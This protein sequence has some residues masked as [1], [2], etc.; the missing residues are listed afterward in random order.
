MKKTILFEVDFKDWAFYFMVKSWSLKLADEYDCYYVCNEAYR[1][2][3]VKKRGSVQIFLWNLLAAIRLFSLK[4]FSCDKRKVQFIHPSGN[5][6]FPRYTKNLIVPFEDESREIEKVNFDFLV[7]MAYFFQYSSD[8]PFKGT[9]NLV[10]IFNDCFP[11]LGPAYDIK[12]KTDVNALSRG[13]FFERYLKHY[14]F[15]LLANDNLINAYKEYTHNLEFALG[16]YKEECFGIK[17]I[18]S[19]IFT[20]GWTGNPHRPVKG[21]F[22]VIEPAVE[23]VLATGRQV[24]LKTSFN[25]SYEKMIEF[26]NDVDLAVIASSGDGAPTMFCEACL[27]HIPSVSTFIG[28]PSMVI[29]DGVNGIFINRDIDEMANAIIYLYDNRDVLEAFS[30]RIKHDYCEIMSNEKNIA[31]IRNVLKKLS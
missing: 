17:K 14:D 8:I 21:F 4:I 22:E 1:I 20:L 3:E 27:S 19:E 11:H 26:Y 10:G 5:Y 28:L 9:K 13:E 30:K 16:I 7:S 12:T 24:R 23:K 18:K 29:Q 6:S 25:A 2:K 31:K 15:L